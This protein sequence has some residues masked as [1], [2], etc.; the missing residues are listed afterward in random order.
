MTTLIVDSVSSRRE[1]LNLVTTRA[2]EW[3]PTV[4][5]LGLGAVFLAHA[6][7]KL[8][9]FTIPGTVAFFQAHGFPGWTVYPVV[10]LEFSGGLA[11]MLGYRVRLASALL[12]PVMLG[13]LVPHL[14]NGWMF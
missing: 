1:Q 4:L 3:A 13:A 8:A 14:G 2:R 10:A 11:L 5:R 9:L 7:A 12:L 6:Y